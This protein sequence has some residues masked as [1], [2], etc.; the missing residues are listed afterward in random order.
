MKDWRAGGEKGNGKVLIA[1]KSELAR[2]CVSER[3]RSFHL[4]GFESQEKGMWRHPHY[5]G[6]PIS[7]LPPQ[8]VLICCFLSWQGKENSTWKTGLD[9]RYLGKKKISLLLLQRPNV[10]WDHFGLPVITINLKHFPLPLPYFFLV[11][12]K[13][14]GTH[15]CGSSN[16]IPLHTVCTGSSI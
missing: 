11:V 7:L 14:W 4:P 3:R 5:W 16:L 1:F 2:T 8:A 15:V 10:L 9:S 13:S 6:S 12:F